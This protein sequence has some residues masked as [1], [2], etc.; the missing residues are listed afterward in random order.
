MLD[1]DGKIPLVRCEDVRKYQTVAQ[2]NQPTVRL[3]EPAG[4]LLHRWDEQQGLISHNGVFGD[5]PGPYP[6]YDAHGLID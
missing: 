4:Y 3:I 6:F 5:Y 2:L 1:Q